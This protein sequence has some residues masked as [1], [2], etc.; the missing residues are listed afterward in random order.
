MCNNIYFLF[1]GS[2]ARIRR[3]TFALTPKQYHQDILCD[4]HPSLNIQ[5]RVKYIVKSDFNQFY[6]H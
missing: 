2:T 6:F 5:G 4:R 3:L 1:F